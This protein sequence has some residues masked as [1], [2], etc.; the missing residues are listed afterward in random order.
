MAAVTVDGTVVE[1]E[2]VDLEIPQEKVDVKKADEAE[3][4]SAGG[5]DVCLPPNGLATKHVTRRN[6]FIIMISLALG[7]GVALEPNLFEGGGVASFYGQNLRNNIGFW[8]RYKTC[9]DYPE[10]TV[11]T[12][13]AT[14]E[15]N[16]YTWCGPS[17]ASSSTPS[18]R[19][20]PLAGRR[21]PTT[22]TRRVPLCRASSRRP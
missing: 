22:S 12:A 11:V 1:E 2:K 7:V 16:G 20:A 8:P 13:P 3:P 14:C 4:E 17:V 6:S 15:V 21:T 19:P 9:K 18:M 5:C 10:V